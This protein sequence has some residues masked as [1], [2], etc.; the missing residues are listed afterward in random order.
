MDF[1]DAY[2]GKMVTIFRKNLLPSSSRWK[3]D[4]PRPS[5][6]FNYLVCLI[7]TFY[8]LCECKFYLYSVSL[9]FALCKF[10]VL[11]TIR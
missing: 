1:G 11:I 8:S 6:T 3:T 4:V 9:H 2:F 7:K 5:K 10:T